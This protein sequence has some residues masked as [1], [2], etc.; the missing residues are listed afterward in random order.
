MTSNLAHEPTLMPHLIIDG[1]N[2]YNDEPC[3]HLGDTIASYKDVR[4]S[5]SQFTQALQSKGLGIGSRVAV[6]S[7]NRLEVLYNISAMQ[8]SGCCGTTLHPLGSLEDHAYVVEDAGIE[9]L[10]YDASLFEE[11][12]KELKERCPSLK[13]LLGFGAT[14]AGEDYTALA[15]TFS[16]A[17]LVAADITADDI[18]SIVYTGGTTGKPKGVMMPYR[19]MAYM[20]MIQMAEWE[21]PDELRMLIATPLSH[22]GAAFFLPALQKGGC[23]YVTQGFSPDIIF[24]MIEQ[25]KIT[26]T[27]LVPVMIYMLLDSP[28]AS[29]ADLSSLQTLFYGASPMSPARLKEGIEKWGKIFYQF[30][31]QSEAPM[32][33]VNMR[34]SKH[35]LSKPERLSA[36]GRPSPWVHLALLDDNGEAVADGEPGEICVRAPLV[37]KEYYNLPEQTAETMAGGWLHTGDVGRFDEDGFLYIVDRTKDMIV[38][39]GFNVFPREVEDSISSHPAVGQVAVVGVPSDQWGEEVKAVIVLRPDIEAS[40]ALSKEIIAQVKAD[41]GSVQAPKSIDYVAGIPLTAVGKPDK[42]VLRGQYWEGRD[43]A[44]RQKSKLLAKLSRAASAALLRCG[45][46][47][48]QHYGGGTMLTDWR[49]LLS[50]LMLLPVLLGG[51]NPNAGQPG[52]SAFSEQTIPIQPAAPAGSNLSLNKPARASGEYQQHRAGKAVDN[53]PGSFWNAGD[54]GPQWIEIDLLGQYPVAEVKLTIEQNPKSFSIHEIY[55]KQQ[56]EQPYKLLKRFKQKT[57]SGQQLQYVPKQPLENIRYLKI[58]SDTGRSW[59]ALRDIAVIAADTTGAGVNHPAAS[60]DDQQATK[61]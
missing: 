58:K 57:Q 43:R 11:R 55:G 35:D 21:W 47:C 19:A 42:K 13:Y 2:R 61:L 38:T 60:P 6:I 51:C 30:Y 36:C 45:G 14:E 59:V 25:H 41:K 7:G 49:R 10:I 37:M 18:G 17:K 44:S 28:R 24:D 20:R 9:A 22:A 53:D 12:A 26:A 52:D 50:P 4:E 15:A 46:R 32:L 31:G 27:M 54:Y 39:G 48:A 8:I 40:E 29:T 33:L 1:L 34:K 23:I 56:F 5:T 3:L 16:P